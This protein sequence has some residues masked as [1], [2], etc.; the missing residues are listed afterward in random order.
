MVHII[1][2]W[3]LAAGFLGAG[4]F[5]A[6]GTT[7]TKTD[8]ARWG[9]PGWWHVLTGALEVLTALLI[10]L[11]ASRI[12]GLALGAIIIL[13]GIATVLRHRDFSHLPPLALFAAV[14][15][16]AALSS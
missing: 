12:P 4:I 9:Y 11:P 1:S 7:G 3:L 10:A 8:F 15:A 16:V 13:A 14:I 5:N 2:V 6:I